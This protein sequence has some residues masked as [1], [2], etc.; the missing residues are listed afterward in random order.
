MRVGAGVKRREVGGGRTKE[1]GEL[2]SDGEHGVQ[3]RL[4]SWRLGVLRE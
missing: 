1:G 3:V 4:L 2:T